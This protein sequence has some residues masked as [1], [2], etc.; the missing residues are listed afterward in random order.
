MD[1]R[2][3]LQ[4]VAA[5]AALPAGSWAQDID[6][7][8][9][10]LLWRV[11]CGDDAPPSHLFGTLHSGDAR[12]LAAVATLRDRLAGAR[13]FMPELVTDADAVTTFMAASMSDKD[14][15]PAQVGRKHWPRVAEMLAL[16]GMDERV[17]R[18]MR[19]WS[20]LLTLLQPVGPPRTT[21]DEVLIGEAVALARPVQ[22]IERV[23]EQIEAIAGLP[24][25]T[26]VA[27]LVDSTNRHDTMQA[28]IEPMTEA[29]LAGHTGELARINARLI[30]DDR[31]LRRHA[32]LFM[33]SLL[34]RRN[35]RFVDRLLPEIRR[36]G[37]FAAFGAAHLVGTHGVLALL[38]RSGCSVERVDGFQIS[39]TVP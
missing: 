6:P 21:L 18:R 3:F 12:V 34:T 4:Q 2:R 31:A 29:W 28:G 27:L 11:H 35:A 7:Y 23:Q 10:G 1:R 38:H 5:L 36:G 13:V 33:Q 15:L 25:D 37:A 20:A 22:P 9:R 16:H 14:S 19:P 8:A 39:P 17:A 30:G 32:H 26:Q 24:M